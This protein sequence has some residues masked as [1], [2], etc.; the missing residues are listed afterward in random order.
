MRKSQTL[1]LSQQYARDGLAECYY[2][3]DQIEKAK[4]LLARQAL[5]P[6]GALI[7]GRIYMQAGESDGALDTIKP[8]L[9][10]DQ[11]IG[12]F[13][14]RHFKKDSMM[15][16]KSPLN[17]ESTGTKEATVGN[18]FLVHGRHKA[19]RESVARFL[20]KLGLHVT[21][22]HEQA[23]RGRTII[24]KFVHHSDVEFAV[25]L[26]TGDDR[27][28]LFSQTYDGQK[29][30]ARQNVILELGFFLGKIGRERVCALY[31]ETVELP[32]DYQGVLFLKYD[33]GGAWRLQLARE[34]R[35]C[36]LPVDLNRAM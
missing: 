34:I 24:E 26:L 11:K 35:A 22:L 5:S 36:G 17:Q 16:N 10:K 6:L 32:S 2:L 9:G 28:G 33:Q 1:D 8:F 25:V 14:E 4:E 15:P 3:N 27:G 12:D 31:D 30:R 23:N 29:A 21:V 13:Y 19:A 7:L 20:E 18:V